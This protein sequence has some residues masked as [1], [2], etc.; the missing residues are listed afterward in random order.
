MA[1]K[2]RCPGDPAPEC[3][4]EQRETLRSLLAK[5]RKYNY[6]GVPFVR[7][8]VRPSGRCMR[9]CVLRAY[10]NPS[11]HHHPF[12]LQL[13]AR[14][15]CCL[16]KEGPVAPSRGGPW[17]GYCCSCR[18]HLLVMLACYTPQLGVRRTRTFLCLLAQIKPQEVTDFENAKEKQQGMAL[19]SKEEGEQVVVRAG[20]GVMN[21]ILTVTL[22]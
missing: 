5:I 20:G 1:C 17:E 14:A 10:Y 22:V 8:S 4:T 19:A 21:T 18:R 16:L 9:A 13:L 12:W 6:R 11:P 15:P 3:G 2:A 7:P